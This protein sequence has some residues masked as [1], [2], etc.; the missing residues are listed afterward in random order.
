MKPNCIKC[1]CVLTTVNRSPGRNTCKA[2][3]LLKNRN[4]NAKIRETLKEKE[5]NTCGIIKK[6]TLFRSASHKKC[7]EC[8]KKN[9]VLISKEEYN[10]LHPN[11]KR[12]CLICKKEKENKE[13]KY[14]TNN[15]R[16]QCNECINNTSN[17]ICLWYYHHY[18]EKTKNGI[19]NS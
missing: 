16:N 7:C 13:F 5:C 17:T 19:L 10:K 2:C 18:L 11:E 1:D 15:Y 8:S 9:F 4:R 6:I 14:H 12:T 3:I